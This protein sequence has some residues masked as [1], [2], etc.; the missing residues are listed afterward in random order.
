MVVMS[1]CEDNQPQ[2]N[3]QQEDLSPF[4]MTYD[5]FI[6]PNDVQ[7]LSPDTT[8]ISVSSSFADKMGLKYFKN[9]AVTIWRTIGTVPF[10]R[11]IT[12]AKVENNEIILTTRKGEFCD[13]FTDV[14]MSLVSDLYVN[15]DYV[16]SR[17]TRTGTNK[18]VTD[19]SGKYIDEEGVY[20]PAVIIFEENSPMARSLQKRTGVAKN[21]YTAE[22][23]LEQNATFN[24][25]D[26]Q[27]DFKFDFRYPRDDDDD[28]FDDKASGIHLKGKVGVEAQ[29]SA[30]A[31]IKV[32]LSSLKMF[33]AGVKG[34]AGVSTMM[35]LALQKQVKDEW[36]QELIP[37]GGHVMIFWVGFVPVPLVYESCIKQKAEASASASLEVLASGK[38][39]LSFEQGCLYESGIGWRNVSKETKSSKS[40]KF[41]GMKGSAKVEASTGIFYEM[42]IYLGGSIGP[43]LSFGPSISAE[44][45]V[46]ASAFINEGVTIEATAGAYAGL[47]GEIGAKIK[48]LGY[49]LAKWETAFDVFKITLYEGSLSW[50]FTE[51]SWG[52][53]ETEW[54][55]LMDR[56]S[57]EW[58]WDE[59]AQVAIPYRLPDSALSF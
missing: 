32:G 42:G 8:L 33:E 20:H 14:E 45:E 23:L 13:M 34:H 37:T 17:S 21:Y 41:N 24:I 11:I 10:I 47:S 18:E 56:G 51:D 52:T 2:M 43:E 12:D 54:A 59:P 55:T 9:R 27:S 15:R 40:F 22:E 6:T 7:I 25:L 39:N 35:S 46:A 29:L 44:A 3:P 5:D 53:L 50:N 36:E 38:Y 28:D 1:A 26:V 57:E 49:N 4:V 16:A 48:F 31:N 58:N 19:I 30:Y